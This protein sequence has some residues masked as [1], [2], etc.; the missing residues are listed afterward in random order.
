MEK[1]PVQV[2]L[3]GKEGD[4]YKIRFPH[5]KIPVTVNEN[6]YHQMLNSDEYRFTSLNSSAKNAYAPQLRKNNKVAL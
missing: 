6:L 4:R 1:K 3:V 5:L 2:Q